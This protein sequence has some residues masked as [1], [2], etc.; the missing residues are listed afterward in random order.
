MERQSEVA[1]QISETMQRAAAEASRIG[2]A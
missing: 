1:G 2:A